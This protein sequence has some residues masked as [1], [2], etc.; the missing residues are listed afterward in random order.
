MKR[1]A[2]CNAPSIARCKISPLWSKKWL[3]G[4]SDSTAAFCLYL[5]RILGEEG[6]RAQPS[7]QRIQRETKN[8]VKSRALPRPNPIAGP[9]QVQPWRAHEDE[10]GPAGV[11]NHRS[12]RAVDRGPGHD[13]KIERP[14]AFNTGLGH[15]V[16]QGLRRNWKNPVCSNPLTRRIILWRPLSK[17][18]KIKRKTF[19]TSNPTLTRSRSNTKRAKRK[20]WRR[21]SVWMSLFSSITYRP[22]LKFWMKLWIPKPW[23]ARC[24]EAPGII[25]ICWS[26]SRKIPLECCK[27]KI[28]IGPWPLKARRKIWKI[29]IC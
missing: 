23:K 4:K 10:S 16:Q 6:H 7:G 18:F 22:M 3:L 24:T 29:K 1:K 28:N 5:G 13:R 25:R 26:R 27:R 19:K 21:S 20:T 14:G 17:L 15:P 8:A 12:S 11:A 9:K 2:T